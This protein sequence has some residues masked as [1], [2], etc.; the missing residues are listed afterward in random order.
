MAF[1][2]LGDGGD[3]VTVAV[4]FAVFDFGKINILVFGGDDVDFV[5]VGF[6]VLS[7]DLMA[8]ANEIVYGG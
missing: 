3:A 6:V 8:V 2:V 5:K 1:F 7:D 4:G